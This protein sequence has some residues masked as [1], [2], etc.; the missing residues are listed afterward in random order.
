[1]K[2]LV[3]D[4]N[5]QRFSF[6]EG[7]VIGTFASATDV[8]IVTN[9]RDGIQKLESTDYDVL[10]VDMAIP[11]TPWS[12]IATENGGIKVLNY[13]LEDESIARPSFIIGLTASDASPPEVLSFFSNSPWILLN[14]GQ[15]GIDWQTRLISLISH[16]AATQRVEAEIEYAI[17]ICIVTA[18]VNPEQSA[19]LKTSV[20]W[21]SEPEFVDSNTVIRRG[22]LAIQN[23]QPLSVISASASRMGSVETALLCSKLIHRFRPRILAMAGICAG[24]EGKVHYGDAILA[25]PVWDW[26]SAKWDKDENGNDRILPAP[27][28]IDCSRE[29][30]SRFKLLAHDEMFLARIR[31]NWQG[32]KPSE[33]LSAHIGPNAS[34]PIVVA[35]G[36]TLNTIKT[37]QNREVLA[38]EM[39][40]YGVY[41]AAFSAGLP[42]PNVFSVKSVCDF[43]DPRKNDDMQKYAAYTSAEV[44]IEF[45]RRYG[46]DLCAQA[47]HA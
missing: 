36:S 41:A 19:V 9:A 45:L 23:G 22:K 3:I 27:H 15:S 35:D 6:F 8:D 24:M 1:M 10:V 28:Y 44:V 43:A 34:G 12:G 32:S 31:Q 18:L 4:D 17:D 39:E 5:P 46:R 13:L 30:V 7:R 38:L 37:T 33:A 16:A 20:V 2:I 25:S 29:I 42:R 11:D 40:A 26:T 47:G 14:I 21:E